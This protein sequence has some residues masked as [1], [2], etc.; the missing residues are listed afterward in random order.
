M[1]VKLVAHTGF[2]NLRPLSLCSTTTHRASRSTAATFCPIVLDEL[3]QQGQ[4]KTNLAKMIEFVFHRQPEGTQLI[5]GLES[6]HG[7]RAP[8]KVIELSRKNRVLEH[9]QFGAVNDTVS[10]LLAKSLRH[11]ASADPEVRLF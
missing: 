3:N 4:D 1:E 2:E 9:A 7:V 10:R 8:G 6:L 5:L 11:A